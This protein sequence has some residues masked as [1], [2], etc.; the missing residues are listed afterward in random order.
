MADTKKEAASGAKGVNP[1]LD[2]GRR[3]YMDR[4]G[5][6]EAA[7]SQW[8]VVAICCLMIAAI[9]TVGMAYT[10]SQN[11]YIPYIVQVDKLGYALP[12][13]FAQ[14]AARADPR[15]VR[16]ELARWIVDTRS[17]YVDAAAERAVLKEAY[18]RISRNGAAFQ[19]L[20]EFFRAN[21]PFDRA[22]KE[23][24]TVE[25]HTVLPVGGTTWRAEWTETTRGRNGEEQ[26]KEEWQASLTTRVDPPTDGTTILENPLGIYITEFSWQ[27]RL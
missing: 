27:K 14:E 11:H 13:G 20:N 5:D 8:R 3:E 26:K 15:I 9:A 10:A 2:R 19:T 6:Q 17:V 25:V 21:S 22:E 4:F 23:T 1:Y 18:A 24:V 12:A 7:K 16:A